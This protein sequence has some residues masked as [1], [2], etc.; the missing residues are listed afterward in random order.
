MPFRN[1]CRIDK[2]PCHGAAANLFHAVMRGDT[3]NI[4]AIRNRFQFRFRCNFSADRGRRAMLDVDRRPHADFTFIAKWFHG[5]SGS[6]LHKADHVRRG[7]D[8]W[9]R[10]IMMV[11]RVLLCHSCPGLSSGAEWNLFCHVENLSDCGLSLPRQLYRG[12][13][14]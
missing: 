3:E 11:Q 8:E 4:K 9:Q 7:I 14:V 1:L 5:V 2:C 12:S 6:P 10:R 13:A